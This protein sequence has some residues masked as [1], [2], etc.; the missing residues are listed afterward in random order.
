M[1]RGRRERALEEFREA[2]RER[3]ERCRAKKKGAASEQPAA[4]PPPSPSSLAQAPEVQAQANRLLDLAF[5]TP[6]P[7]RTVFGE[8][9]QTLI[10]ICTQLKNSQQHRITI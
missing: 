10:E 1:A 4:G 5:E 7:S 8:E 6:R 9:V 3:Q 2:E